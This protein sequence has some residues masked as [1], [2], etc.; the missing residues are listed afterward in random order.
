MD[1][2]VETATRGELH[3]AIILHGPAADSLRE[4]AVQIAK[5]LNCLK[6]TSGDR[7]KA[8]VRIGKR[9]HPDVHFIEVG[10]ERKMISIEQ[11]R[12]LLEGASMRPYEGRNKVFIIDPADALSIAGSNSLLKTLEEPTR[13]TTFLLLTRSPDLLL[14]TIRSR[15]QAIYVGGVATVDEELRATII[16]ALTRFSEQDDATALLALAA[17]I[18]GREDVKDAIALL[19]ETLCDAVARQSLQI[20]KERLLAAA[21]AA[22]AAIRWLGVNADP[23]ML[24]EQALAELVK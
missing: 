12:E 1:V 24:V 22:M 17:A 10:G 7:C 8:C 18:G 4:T 19:A 5:A 6:G 2:V 13:D 11:I 23:R 20:P 15:S 3:H 21:D 14:P 9:I 16:A